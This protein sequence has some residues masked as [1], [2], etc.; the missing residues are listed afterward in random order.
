MDN[1]RK[2]SILNR[3]MTGIVYR[4]INGNV[5]KLVPPTK[6][7]LALSHMIYS[8]ILSDNSYSELMTRETATMFLQVK[9]IWTIE[10][11]DNL[12][13]LNDH[14]DNLKVEL[15]RKLFNKKV[16]DRIRKQ[17]QGTYKQIENNL[18][19]KYIFE[20]KT[21]E[22]YAED[23]RDRS[24]KALCITDSS[25]RYVYDANSLGLQSKA[26]MTSLVSKFED[27]FITDKEY[28]FISRNDPF[29]SDWIIGKTNVFGIRACNL[30]NEQKSLILYSRMYDNVYDSHDR[31][32]EDVIND[33]YMLDGWFIVQRRKSDSDQK[34]KETEELLGNK[35][36]K[37]GSSGEMFV[38]A[39]SPEE[40]NRIRELNDLNSK[41]KMK[42]RDHAIQER[43]S[44]DEQDL[45]D[46]KMDIYNQAMRQ[47]AEKRGK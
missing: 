21:L 47:A 6:D 2:T 36:A 38:M 26:E 18:Y 39:E 17:I 10:K 29:R 34:Q 44:V 20:D 43:G 23:I 28:R 14:I 40:A 16:Q 15:Y 33:D 12:K 4:T 3:V 11:E 41:M 31:P 42:Q 27:P 37:G 5:Y 19:N 24:L 25:G 32:S 9:G 1:Y 45:P 35:G 13:K 46:V 30:S 8:N 22:Y 7:Q